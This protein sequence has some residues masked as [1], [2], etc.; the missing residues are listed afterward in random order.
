MFLVK[1]FHPHTPPM[2]LHSQP[3][4]LRSF[5]NAA[6]TVEV[7]QW[8]KQANATMGRLAHSALARFMDFWGSS[9]IQL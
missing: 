2:A 9:F 4:T 1:P 8:P 6:A 3:S 5:S 7:P